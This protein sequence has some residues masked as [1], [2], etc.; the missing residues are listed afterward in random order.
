MN[1]EEEEED[2]YD[3]IAGDVCGINAKVGFLRFNDDQVALFRSHR[4]FVDGSRIRPSETNRLA[5]FTSFIAEKF[6]NRPIMA[7]VKK[8]TPTT[9]FATHDGRSMQPTWYAHAVW[10][11]DPEPD[12]R[13]RRYNKSQHEEK[14]D[15]GSNEDVN[16][17]E[18]EEE[19]EEDGDKIHNA[20]ARIVYRSLG[21]L[22]IALF[23]D[24]DGEER[25]T[26]FAFRHLHV[27]GQVVDKSVYDSWPRDKVIPDATVDAH[28]IP[29]HQRVRVA[30][31]SPDGDP[32]KAIRYKPAWR[33]H[34]VFVG[35]RPKEASLTAEKEENKAVNAA[36]KDDF[37]ELIKDCEYVCGRLS[38][39]VDRS[40]GIVTGKDR[41]V[42]FKARELVVDG[43]KLDP[44]ERLSSVLT[45]G[46]SLFAFVKPLFPVKKF[47]D[48]YCSAIAKVGYEF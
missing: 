18:E 38:A 5:K 6:S 32:D 15:A 11:G 37:K 7:D 44:D 8:M 4:I 43:R 20:A 35:V 12:L 17:D 25:C 27:D 46:E 22:G 29:E 30:V 9:T 47:G 41:N 26:Q 33:C 40:S 36:K 10:I 21:G 2:K 24:P 48:L 13:E 45:I 1:E 34:L 19:E 16:M 23:K 14:P 42:L 28:K 39:F 31:M 3:R